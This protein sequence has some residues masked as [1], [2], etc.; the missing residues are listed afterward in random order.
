MLNQEKN[1]SD[2]YFPNNVPNV[3]NVPNL[4]LDDA[5]N[6]QD[7]TLENARKVIDK[8]LS[9]C[10]DH[11]GELM[12]LKFLDAYKQIRKADPKLAAEYRVKIKRAKPSGILLS[13]IDDSSNPVE[14]SGSDSACLLYTSPSPR[15]S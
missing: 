4:N 10:K 7:E 11:P 12:S 14:G 13:E 9:S 15:D 3:P 8:V 6:V 5:Q 2:E 1:L